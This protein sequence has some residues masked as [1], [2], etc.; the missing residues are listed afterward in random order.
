MIAVALQAWL[1]WMYG[2][3]TTLNAVL[4][5][6]ISVGLLAVIG[7]LFWFV[8]DVIRIIQAN[9]ILSVVAL[10]CW[11]ICCLAI[12][13][14][15]YPHD[16]FSRFSGTIPLRLIIGVLYWIILFQWYRNILLKRWKRE[17]IATEAVKAPLPET[18]D[19]I[20]IKNG[21]R[22]HVIPVRDITHIQACGDYVMLFTPLGEHLKEQTMKS[23][24][25]HL[26]S[27]FVRIHRSY[28]VNV[29]QIERVELFA[30]ETYHVHLKN[31]TKIRASLSG[32]K[33]L[34]EVLSM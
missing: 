3:M 25:S 20:A 17:T 27:N 28:I 26:P 4:D 34:K 33:L 10:A 12:Y 31:G 9:I 8:I 30:K 7:Y 24:E 11:F 2:G 18:A 14:L 1:M 15:E 21:S 5:S 32:Y 19:R 16:V 22:I 29:E 13:W 6:I 23:L